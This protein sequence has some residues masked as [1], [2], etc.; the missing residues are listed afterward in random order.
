MRTFIIGAT[1][2]ASA[3]VAA[4]AMAEDAAPA[5][6]PDFTI[7]GGATLVSDYRFRGVSYLR[8]AHR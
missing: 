2:L 3:M 8:Q 1:A 4:P 7:N 5:E 6:T